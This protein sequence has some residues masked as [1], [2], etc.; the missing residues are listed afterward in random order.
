MPS[1]ND[2]ANYESWKAKNQDP[3]SRRCFTYAEVWADLMEVQIAEGK[4]IAECAK[5]TSY[6]ADTDGITA[7]MYGMAVNI[8]ASCWAYGEV[9]RRW[10]NLDTQIGDEGER[11]NQEGSVLNPALLNIKI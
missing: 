4:T 10:H 7:F 11:A 9:L 1:W 2:K 8:L 3:Y 6:V 5:P